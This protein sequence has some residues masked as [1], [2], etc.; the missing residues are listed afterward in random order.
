MRRLACMAWLAALLT[1]VAAC[2]GRDDGTVVPRPVAYPRVEIPDSAYRRVDVDGLKLRV[3]SIAEVM[4]TPVDGGA[5][6][7]ISYPVFSSPRMYLTLTECGPGGLDDVLANRRE[8]ESLNLGGRRYELTELSTP[9]G[10]NCTMSVARGAMTTPVQ[11]LA[12]D[13][14][15]V[16]S[17]ALMLSL[18]DSLMADPTVIAPAVEAVE[19]DMIVLL[20]GLDGE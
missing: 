18:P 1:S 3:N 20:K 2:G 8:R 15:R 16:L 10:W 17:G 9:G 4:V 6:V 7:D 13:D 14:R 12:H 5:W 11:I 19:R